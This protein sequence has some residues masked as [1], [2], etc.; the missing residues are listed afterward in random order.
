MKYFEKKR[1]LSL[2]IHNFRYGGMY[3]WH[4]PNSSLVNLLRN[5]IHLFCSALCQWS[6]V[7]GTNCIANFGNFEQKQYNFGCRQYGDTHERS[8]LFLLIREKKILIPKILLKKL[9]FSNKISSQRNGRENAVNSISLKEHR[10]WNKKIQMLSYFNGF[11]RIDKCLL[12]LQQS[13][14]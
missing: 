13:S 10:R 4:T 3:T 12:L 14:S 1:F 8:S 9:Y 2:F 6:R 11:C 5:E 7:N